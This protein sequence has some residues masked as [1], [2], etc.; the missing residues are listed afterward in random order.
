MFYSISGRA[1]LYLQS[2]LKGFYRAPLPGPV[3][4]SAS[5]ILNNNR[6]KRNTCFPLLIFYVPSSRFHSFVALSLEKNGTRDRPFA[7]RILNELTT[8]IRPNNNWNNKGFLAW[9]R[10][11]NYCPLFRKQ[12]ELRA[13]VSGREKVPFGF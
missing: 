9:W 10:E 7:K 8:V 5:Q 11:Q 2:S 12:A 1:L 3:F 13:I 4:L 6:L